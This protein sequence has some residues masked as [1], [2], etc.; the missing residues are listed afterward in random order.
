L[1]ADE[2]E[3]NMTSLKIVD[4]GAAKSVLI[5]LRSVTSNVKRFS[6]SRVALI[7]QS[8]VNTSFVGE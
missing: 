7:R 4:A 3:T 1:I 2:N 5:S 6:V 8:K